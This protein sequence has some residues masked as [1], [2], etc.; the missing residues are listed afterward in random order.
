M[1]KIFTIL[2]VM[3]LL[4]VNCMAQSEEEEANLFGLTRSTTGSSALS[5]DFGKIEKAV[6]ER[7]VTIENKENATMK[8][9]GFAVPAGVSAMSLQKSIEEFGKGRVKI[10]VDPNY[11]GAVNG[12]EIVINVSYFDRK[13]N[14][15][16]NAQL[17]YKIKSE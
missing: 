1:K 3:L 7:T 16:K 17:T 9:T 4:S 12:E 11:S 10:I 5:V 15:S 14:Q 2:S 8:I 13:G 6:V